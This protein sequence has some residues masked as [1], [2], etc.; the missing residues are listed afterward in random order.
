[1]CPSKEHVTL[2]S[3]A[4]QEWL[5]NVTSRRNII[6]SLSALH[7]FITSSLHFLHQAQTSERNT[8]LLAG[9]R[10]TLVHMVPS[11]SESLRWC[12]KH[13]GTFATF[14]YHWHIIIIII[15]ALTS[16]CSFRNQSSFLSERNFTFITSISWLQLFFC[17]LT[18]PTPFCW[19]LRNDQW[20]WQLTSK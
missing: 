12:S 8:K 2:R 6:A 19:I 10:E 13:F 15:V 5:A 1:M 4:A 17:C 18:I 9:W 11:C 14:V 20:Q 3:R 16:Y 7:H